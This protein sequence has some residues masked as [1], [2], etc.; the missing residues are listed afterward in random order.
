MHDM[1]QKVYGNDCL[2][3]AQVF[4]W[5]KVFNFGIEEIDNEPCALRSSSSQTSDNVTK[6]KPLLSDR[7]INVRM[8]RDTLKIAQLTVL[9]I[10]TEELQMHKTSVNLDTIHP[11]KCCSILQITKSQRLC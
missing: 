8:I 3:K 5:Q 7:W 2:S 11:S 9:Q 4:M 1:L 6:I 10:F